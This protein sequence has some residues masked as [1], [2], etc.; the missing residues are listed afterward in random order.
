[1]ES[2]I[3]GSQLNILE[4]MVNGGMVTDL[5][6][7]IIYCNLPV[8]RISGYT[9]TESKGMSVLTLHEEEDDEPYKNVYD[10]IRS[11]APLQLNWHGIRKDSSRVWLDISANILKDDTG[12]SD[13]CVVSPHV[14]E[15]IKRTKLQL[16]KYKT[17]AEAIPETSVDTILSVNE[18]GEIIRANTA[19]TDLFGYE[20]GELIGE[21]IAVLIPPS[22]KEYAIRYLEN[23]KKNIEKKIS[24]KGIEIN[25]L[26]K[27]GTECPIELSVAEVTWDSRKIYTVIIKDMTNR[28]DLER[29]IIEIG[30]DERRGIG[31]QL[32]D[33]LGQMLTG[34]R[35]L[36]ENLAEKLKEKNVS[37]ADG[38]NEIAEMIWNADEYA[39]DM[40]HGMVVAELEN[41]G[42][43]QA[44]NSLCERTEKMT[45][46]CCTFSK[47]EGA[48][49]DDFDIA[50]HL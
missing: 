40:S 41:K 31:R 29:R 11:N 28:R 39:R 25:A 34:N 12:G 32:Q 37:E 44:I 46:F 43:I 2:D 30:K 50:L 49:I 23:I 19:V 36:S 48:E 4:N 33:G 17:F 16:E 9:T 27:D 24:E 5:E 15:D 35:L 20:Q 47:E 14:I 7:H 42:F 6:G 22:L 18:N 21:S 10:K 1:M 13:G 38:V 45:R 26:K 3:I 8:I